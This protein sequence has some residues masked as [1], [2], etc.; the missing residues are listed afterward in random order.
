M[1]EHGLDEPHA[2]KLKKLVVQHMLDT[3]LPSLVA[4]EENVIMKEPIVSGEEN[5]FDQFG[6]AL[7]EGCA[8]LDLDQVR[9]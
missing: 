8:D 2:G 4:E 5:V 9:M 6:T 3:V 1:L 7:L